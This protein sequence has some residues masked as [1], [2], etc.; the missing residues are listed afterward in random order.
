MAQL[1]CSDLRLG[2][3]GRTVLSGVSFS[4]DA[5]NY[6]CVV[7][8]N[9]SGKSTLMKTVLG[10]LKPLGGKITWGEGLRENETEQKRSSFL[11]ENSYNS[12]LA[13]KIS[14]CYLHIQ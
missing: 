6:L 2:Y 1:T 10:L 13:C 4:V 11:L 5:G 14:T 12:P 8:E 3:E 7:G 9:G